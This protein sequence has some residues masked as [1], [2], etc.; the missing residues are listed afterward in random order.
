MLPVVALPL[1]V[2]TVCLAVYDLRVK[3]VPNWVTLPLLIGGI[4][5]NFPSAP[6][7]WL[8]CGL[9][10]AT[11]RFGGMGA[12]D[13]KLWLALLWL[14]PP[15]LAFQAL[16]VMGAILFATALAQIAWR[17]LRKTPLTG[18]RSPG[19]WRAIPFALWLLYISAAF[20]VPGAG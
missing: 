14:A 17:K 18:V 3:R 16:M 10:F 5:L 2:L 9:L 13:A 19:A 15:G 12:G 1:F 20:H 8:G 11:W 4:V 6:E 7:T